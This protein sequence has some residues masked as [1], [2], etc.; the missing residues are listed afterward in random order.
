MGQ[1]VGVLKQSS[2]LYTEICRTDQP[3]SFGK[4]FKGTYAAYIARP[5]DAHKPDGWLKISQWSYQKAGYWRDDLE[6]PVWGSD[7][8]KTFK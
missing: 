4:K 2:E 8:A 5:E 1:E 7:V 6:K 3:T